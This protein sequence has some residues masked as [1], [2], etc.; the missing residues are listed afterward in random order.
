MLTERP[1]RPVRE[2]QGLHMLTGVIFG[3]KAFG[4]KLFFLYL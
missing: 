3:D 2:H 4:Q 1:F